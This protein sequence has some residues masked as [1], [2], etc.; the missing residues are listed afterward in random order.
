[1]TTNKIRGVAGNLIRGTKWGLKTDA[2]SG[3]QGQSPGG[4]L[5]A[6]PQKLETNMDAKFIQKQ[7]KFENIKHA[8][9]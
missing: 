8:N 6:K 2:P 3:V 9:T 4:N 1:M 7:Y 5:G